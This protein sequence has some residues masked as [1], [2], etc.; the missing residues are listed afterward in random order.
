MTIYLG[1]LLSPSF[2]FDAPLSRLRHNALTG[3][4]HV[5]MEQVRR[6]GGSP[7]GSKHAFREQRKFAVLLIVGYPVSV[8]VPSFTP[9]HLEDNIQLKLRGLQSS[10]ICPSA[11]ALIWWF[12][13]L[14][15]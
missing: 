3:I 1:Y 8:R 6:V 14:A 12:A 15:T 4:L 10:K 7:S 13:P 9:R 5:G 11:A 2:S